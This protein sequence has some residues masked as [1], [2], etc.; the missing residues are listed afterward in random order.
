MQNRN[1]RK[2]QRERDFSCL[3]NPGEESMSA[4]SG[5]L[6]V[7]LPAVCQVPQSPVPCWAFRVRVAM[8]LPASQARCCRPPQVPA[9]CPMR[10]CAFMSGR[11]YALTVARQGLRSAVR[12]CPCLMPRP[13]DAASAGAL[14]AMSAIQSCSDPSWRSLQRSALRVA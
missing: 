1:G 3:S 9:P 14:P 12:S 8:S 5:C 6:R 10:C 11:Q 4:M 2:S 13:F 7:R